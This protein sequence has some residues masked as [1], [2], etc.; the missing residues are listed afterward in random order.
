M[1]ATKTSGEK[2]VVLHAIITE[3]LDTGYMVRFKP[4]A[5]IPPG[6]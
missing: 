1:H 2:E 3:R 6:K 5:A 4:M